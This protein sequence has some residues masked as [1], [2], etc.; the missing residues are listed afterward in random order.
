MT[1]QSPNRHFHIKNGEIKQLLL[2]FEKKNI[3]RI[4]KKKDEKN[5]VGVDIKIYD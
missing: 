5:L 4:L 2:L 1:H 3:K